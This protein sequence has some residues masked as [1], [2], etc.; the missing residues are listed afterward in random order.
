MIPVAVTRAV[1]AG[2]V[3][4][5]VIGMLSCF[6]LLL[7]YEPHKLARRERFR[8]IP[9]SSPRIIRIWGSLV[10]LRTESVF[11]ITMGSKFVNCPARIRMCS[12]VIHIKE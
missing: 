9:P 1:W 2:V 8:D 11:I 6:Y 12:S 7:N 5:E 4:P 10:D 3:E